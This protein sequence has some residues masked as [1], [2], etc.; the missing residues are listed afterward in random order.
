MKFLNT[1]NTCQITE[2][3]S[4]MSWWSGG[5]VLDQLSEGLEIKSTLNFHGSSNVTLYTLLT[6]L[7]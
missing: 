1:L 3:S 6:S 7:N 4:F 5:G 2:I